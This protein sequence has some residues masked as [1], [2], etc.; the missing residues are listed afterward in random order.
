[1]SGFIY[2]QEMWDKRFSIPEYFFGEA[3][4]AF[5]ASRA[6]RLRSGKALA[7]ALALVL[8]DGDCR[9]SVWLARQGWMVDAFDFQF[10]TSH[11]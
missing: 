1:M 8:A 10:A 6:H 4:N 9:N 5:W 3:P 7:L 2:P 11:D